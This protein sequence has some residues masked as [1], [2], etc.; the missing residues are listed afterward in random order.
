MIG[1]LHRI[2]CPT[3]VLGGADDP[4]HP[5][6]SQADIAAALPQHLVQRI[7]GTRW[8]PMP[9]SATITVIRDYIGRC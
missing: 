2:Q 9:L 7:A 4:I 6:E 1:D 5:I 3:L 8:S